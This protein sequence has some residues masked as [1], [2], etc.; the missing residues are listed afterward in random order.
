MRANDQA[1][2][3]EGLHVDIASTKVRCV[4]LAA[5]CLA[6]NVLSIELQQRPEILRQ[7]LFVGFTGEFLKCMVGVIRAQDA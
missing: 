6:L 3:H 5:S 1:H 2:V 4:D 7:Q